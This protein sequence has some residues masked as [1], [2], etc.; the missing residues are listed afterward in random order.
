[1]I[2]SDPRSKAELAKN[3]KESGVFCA[4]T[5]NKK[6]AMVK[7]EQ[8][9]RTGHLLAKLRMWNKLIRPGKEQLSSELAFREL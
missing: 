1:M 3:Q 2:K 5:V 8:P 9:K 4:F 7:K 6:G